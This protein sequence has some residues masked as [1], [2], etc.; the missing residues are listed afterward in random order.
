MTSTA[1]HSE[2]LDTLD[3]ALLSFDPDLE[4]LFAEVDAILCEAR[5]RMPAPPRTPV[6]VP[7]PRTPTSS[8][9]VA[10]PRRWR[11]NRPPQPVWA[12]QRGPPPRHGQPGG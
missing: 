12:T 7:G 11:R 10:Y 2:S 8:V 1:T 9:F 3:A 4:Q 6:P 5:A